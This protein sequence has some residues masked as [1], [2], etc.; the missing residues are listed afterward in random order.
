MKSKAV[1]KFIYLILVT[2]AI[3]IGT[4]LFFSSRLSSEAVIADIAGV[5]YKIMNTGELVES[6]VKQDLFFKLIKAA[7]DLTREETNWDDAL[8]NKLL[9]KISSD[10]S[11]GSVTY[12]NDMPTTIDIT[13]IAING[14][15]A[16][17]NYEFEIDYKYR[18]LK[19]VGQIGLILP[20]SGYYYANDV[21][22]DCPALCQW[23]EKCEGYKVNEYLVG[24]CLE[25]TTSCSYGCK[26]GYCG[27][28]CNYDIGHVVSDSTC[29]YGSCCGNSC[30][31]EGCCVCTDTGCN[32][33]NTA[34]LCP[35]DGC[36]NRDSGEAANDW[37]DYPSYGI[38]TTDCTCNV[39]TEEGEPCE[40]VIEYNSDKCINFYIPKP[41]I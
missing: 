16:M 28:H 19:R 3:V 29:Y 39:G 18:N 22:E 13:D 6:F 8:E 20:C 4:G 9:E 31:I 30:E 14:R 5:N 24:K 35:T 41:I 2:I 1:T 17:L 34:C 11:Y 12:F 15:E 37:V 26:S 23:C 33:D 7:K 36:E 32:P 38:C 40:P 21:K 27:A 25:P 10:P